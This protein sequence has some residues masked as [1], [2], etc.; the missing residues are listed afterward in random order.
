MNTKVAAFVLSVVVSLA[1]AQGAHAGEFSV[2]CSYKNDN[3]EKCASVLSDVVTDKFVAKYSAAKFQI[4]VHSSIFGFTDG[5]YSAYAVAGVV[6]KN[7]GQFPLRTF[8]STSVNSNN[9]KFSAVE[10]AGF[11][12]DVY[13]SAVRSLMEQCQIS[14]DCDVYNPRGK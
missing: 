1:T 8:S 10:L 6:P 2:S 3:I 9:K 14:A 4:F 11:E 5:G 13:R 7:S 12:L